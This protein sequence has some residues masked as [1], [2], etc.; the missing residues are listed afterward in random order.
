MKTLTR[1][2]IASLAWAMPALA[3]GQVRDEGRSFLMVLF[4]GFGALILVSQLLPGLALFAVTLKEIVTGAC[5]KRTITAAG[6]AA[7]KL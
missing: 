2:L 4:L 6:E 3:A 7:R 5:K 1:T